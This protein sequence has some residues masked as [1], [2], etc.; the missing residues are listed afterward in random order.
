MVEK[1]VAIAI[2]KLATPDSCRWVANQFGVGKSTTGIV[3][4]QVY[5]AINRIL[6]RRTVTLGNMHDTVAG[7]AQMGF[8]N[9]GGVID[10]MHIPI[11][12]PAHLACEYVNQKGYFLMVLQA[13]VGHHGRFTDIKAGWSEKVHDA[14]IFW[15]TGLF[16]KLQDGTFFPDQKITVGEVKMP[17]VILGDPTYPL[18]L[19]L[20]KPYTG[21]L[22]STKEWF[23][24]RLSRCRITVECAFGRLKGNWRSLYGKLDLADDSIPAVISACYTSITFVKGRVKDSLRHG[25]WRFNT[26]RLNLNSQRAGLLEGPSAGLQG[27]GMP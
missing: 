24:N 7:F 8:P 17:I 23:N 20:M 25:T 26:W 10:G 6:L 12:A 2:W 13:L 11:L 27:L 22:D 15:N 16:R 3:L 21:S 5:R 18:M 14:C 1:Q 9:C 19:W 4:M